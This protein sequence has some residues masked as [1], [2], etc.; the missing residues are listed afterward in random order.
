MV[1]LDFDCEN[2]EY[3]C[4]IPKLWMEHYVVRMKKSNNE[5]KRFF[6]A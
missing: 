1:K 6:L 3:C 5:F 4:Y 2:P